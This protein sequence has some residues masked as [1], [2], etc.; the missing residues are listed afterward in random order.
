MPTPDQIRL[1]EE[2]AQPQI[3]RL[4]RALQPLR[5]VVSFMNTGAHPDDET[6]AMLA[7][8]AFRDGIDISYACSTRGEGGQN[9]IGMETGAA[10][11]TLRTAEMEAAA[12]VLNLRLYWLGISP[13]DPISDFGFSKSGVETLDKWGLDTTLQRFV[14][15][16]RTERPDIICPTF[17]DVPGQHGHHRAMTEAARLVMDLAADPTFA[18]DLPVWQVK[19]LYLPAWSGAGQ[20]YDDDLLPPPATLT[21]EAQGVEPITG[22]SWMRIGEQSRAFHRTQGM[23]RWVPAGEERDFPLHLADS[24][25]LGPDVTLSSGLPA[26]LADLDVPEIADDLRAAHDHIMSAIDAFPANTEILTEASAALTRIRAAITACPKSVHADIA[27][28]LARKETQLSQVIRIAAGVEVFGRTTDT[29]LRPGSE[30]SLSVETRNGQATSVAV[31]PILSKGWAQRDD[32]L[33]VAPDAAPSTPYPTQYFPDTPTAP[34]LRVQVTAEGMISETDVPLETTPIIL[35]AC[36]AQISP[37]RDVLNLAAPARDLHIAVDDIYPV[38]A[39]PALI[40]PSGWIAK[41]TET[42][43]TVTAPDDVAAGLY[44]LPLTLDGEPA[45]SVTPIVHAHAAA[46]AIAVPAQLQIRAVQAKLPE[47]KV[48]YIGGGNDRVDHWLGRLGANV[49]TLSDPELQSEIAL[50][51]Y[52]TIVIGIFAMRFRVGLVAAMPRLHDWVARGGTL[53]TL[54]HRPWDNWDPKTIPPARLE[55]GQP[56]LRWRVTDETAPVTMTEPQH[57]VLT[58]PNQIDGS[59]WADWHKERGLYFSKS[60]DRAYTPLLEM[61]DP[62]E[63]PLKGALLAADIGAGRHIHCALILHHQMEHLTPG[64][65][66]L[67]ANLLAK[68]E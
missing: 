47:V 23:G 41:R 22:F 37:N 21:I 14:D 13:D 68:R 2:R 46:R 66:R 31:T 67:M 12:N 61:S 39:T 5:S 62:G 42:G 29:F 6:S 17:L 63:D 16:I 27:H 20:S 53:V 11:G 26:T 34:F 51:A 60:W 59:D 57:P 64:A 50:N 19:K 54:Y 24:R 38:G 52:D 1:M 43:F 9:D 65:F 55:I 15:I 32:G 48:G 35:P 3:V 8:L 49:R 44:T 40:L 28:K 56:S 10:L 25:V 36:S 4:W 33:Q 30:T 58:T 18:S 45:Q 7:A